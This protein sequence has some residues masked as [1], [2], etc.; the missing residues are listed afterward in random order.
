MRPTLESYEALDGL[1][2]T[3]WLYRPTGAQ[4]AGA[5][6]LSFHGGP[7]AQER[8]TFSPQH[9]AL[10]AAGFTVFAPNIRGSSGYGRAFV[11]ADDR[12]GRWDAISD[13]LATARFL[14]DKGWAD[15]SRIAVTG[16][17][18]GGYLT[19]AALVRYPGAFAAGVD[20]CGMSDLHTFYRDS[21]PWIAAAAVSKY[22][23]P[24][25]DAD[26]LSELSP[27]ARADLIDVPLL[28]VHGELDTNVPIN[29]ARQIVSALQALH[30]PVRYLELPGEGHEYRRADTKKLLL[31]TML[32][33]LTAAPAVSLIHPLDPGPPRILGPPRAGS[34]AA[35]R[36]WLRL[37]GSVCGWLVL[38]AAARR[39]CCRASEMPTARWNFDC[40]VGR[41]D[42]PCSFE[43]AG[44]PG[45]GFGHL[46]G[47][48][49]HRRALARRKCLCASEM[50]TARWNFDCAVGRRDAPC[51]FE[52]AGQAGGRTHRGLKAPGTPGPN[53][54]Q[55]RGLDTSPG[56]RSPSGAGASEVLLR[57]GNG[58]CALEL[59][60][61]RGSQRRAVQLRTR[62][63]AWVRAPGRPASKQ[64]GGSGLGARGTG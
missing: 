17:S 22:G 44:Q 1:P 3:G 36:K 63:T 55:G 12:N 35:H 5:T 54:A 29:E 14:I 15:P 33:F 6:V 51:S 4:E 59:R 21:E 58:H 32:E 48:S 46:G 16:R 8:P 39:K 18:Y 37:A 52:R 41:R 45:S 19:L 13:A 57:I 61:R 7:E 11:H 40:A 23:D 47:A 50:A 34:V 20:I 30:R 24:V 53:T 64:G 56:I 42:A 28:V 25:V 2:L 62:R 43:R 60:L 27:L 49:D 10:A 9:Q 26:L 38:S 31:S